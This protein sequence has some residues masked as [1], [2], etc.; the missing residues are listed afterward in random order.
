MASE[1]ISR[2]RLLKRAGAGAAVLWAA[3][4][5]TSG[6]QAGHGGRHTCGRGFQCGGDCCFNQTACRPFDPSCTCIQR[7]QSPG[8]P[9]RCF[10]HQGGVCADLHHCASNK[11]CP[12]G[13]ACACSC[14]S[15]DAKA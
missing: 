11:D 14:C 7:I 5:L 6:A 3:P 2:G 4:V 9:R 1:N 10:C 15:Y 12:E 8:Q 13:W